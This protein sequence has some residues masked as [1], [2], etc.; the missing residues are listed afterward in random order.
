MDYEQVYGVTEN[1]IHRTS[2]MERGEAIFHFYSW[3][4]GLIE[5]KKRLPVPSNVSLCQ[6]LINS[7]FVK[8]LLVYTVIIESKINLKPKPHTKL[9][10]WRVE[11]QFFS[12]ISDILAWLRE[13]SAC[14][15]LQKVPLPIFDKL[16]SSKLLFQIVIIV[17]SLD[18]S[19]KIWDRNLKNI[20]PAT[21]NQ[22][23][24]TELLYES[25]IRKNVKF[26]TVGT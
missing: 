18:T 11:N 17:L 15:C 20:C 21:V 13:R 23:L 19:M 16:Y 3:Y 25:V 12:F 26:C 2:S 4:S 24:H 14:P 1:A 8:F 5:E 9:F 22:K 7:I 10:P 6:F